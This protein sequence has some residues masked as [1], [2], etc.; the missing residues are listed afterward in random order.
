MCCLER[1]LQVRSDKLTSQSLTHL[2]KALL[3]IKV[4]TYY[5]TFTVTC[6]GRL[7]RP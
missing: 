3:V 7:H 2:H 4:P 6:T 1:K 5:C